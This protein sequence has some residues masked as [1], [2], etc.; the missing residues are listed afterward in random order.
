MGSTICCQTEKPNT[1][2]EKIVYEEIDTT[3]YTKKVIKIQS[4]I[5][6]VNYRLRFKIINMN[7]C[8]RVLTRKVTMLSATQ[9]DIFLNSKMPGKLIN[10]ES[11]TI[12][13]I[14]S[15]IEEKLGDFVIEEKEIIKCIEDEKHKLRNFTIEYDDGSIYYGYYNRE[16]ERQGYGILIFP[17]G[18]KYQGFFKNN[19]MHGRGRLVGAQGDYYWGIFN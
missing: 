2:K 15:K 14:V 6:G 3:I 7:K 8:L 10:I 18:S 16:W 13:E 12:N 9:P 1:D 11:I 4:F 19:K 5:R 17:D